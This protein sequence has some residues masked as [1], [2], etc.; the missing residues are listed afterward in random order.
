MIARVALLVFTLMLGGCTGLIFQP[1]RQH[2]LVPAEVGVEARDEWFTAADGTRLHA[3]FLPARGTARGTVLFL[4][5]NAENISTH[6]A[7]VYWMPAYGYQV[8]LFDYRGYG[9]SEG[10]PSLPGI[11]QDFA[12]AL[13]YVRTLPEVDPT[14]IVVFGQSMGGATAIT[15]LAHSPAR[16]SVRAL[17]VEGAPTSYRSLARELL[18]NSWLTWL[19]QWPLSLTISDD[20]RPIDAVDG[21]SPVPLLVVHSRDDEVIPSHHG[22]ALHAA[23]REPRELWLVDGARHIAAFTTRE[24]RERLVA[25]LDARLSADAQ[26]P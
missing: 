18:S 24:R 23:A 1:M 20:Y 8:L 22:V 17:V 16:A 4:H 21:I 10:K 9:Y 26:A 19:F 2:A 12:A 13:E 7:S 3:W 25:W 6:L 14:R 11:H 15:G 5:G